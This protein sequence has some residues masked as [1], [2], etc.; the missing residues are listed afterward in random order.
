[1]EQDDTVERAKVATFLD[2]FEDRFYELLGG[3][4]KRRESQLEEE[5]SIEEQPSLRQNR[6][7]GRKKLKN[8]K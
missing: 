3:A 5:A 2:R 6:S 4:V 8:K 1:L 7:S